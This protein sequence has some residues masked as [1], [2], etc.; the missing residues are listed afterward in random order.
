MK[1]YNWN[2]RARWFQQI[3]NKNEQKTTIRETFVSQIP[4]IP[5]SII[6]ET[7]YSAFVPFIFQM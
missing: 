4:I 2:W 5:V 7:I 1:S 6:R 3:D